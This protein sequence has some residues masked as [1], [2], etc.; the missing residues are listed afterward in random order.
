MADGTGGRADSSPRTEADRHPAGA[1]Q[2]LK[3]FRYVVGSINENALAVWTD[4]WREFHHQVTPSG[5]V[6]PQLQQGFVPSCG[7]AEFL[8]KFWLLKHYLDCI[9]HIA[10]ED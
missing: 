10:R 2:A 4:L 8:E 5:L 9:H 3:H 1:G 7:W 6:T